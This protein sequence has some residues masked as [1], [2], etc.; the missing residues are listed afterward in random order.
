[1]SAWKAKTCVGSSVDIVEERGYPELTD[2]ATRKILGENLARLHG[3]DVD[4]KKA[5]L[6]VPG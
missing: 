1:M 5:E 3:I 2:Q 4:A 6:G